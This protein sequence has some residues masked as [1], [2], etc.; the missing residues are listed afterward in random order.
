MRQS[1]A[2]YDKAYCIRSWGGSSYRGTANLSVRDVLRQA[3]DCNPVRLAA[4]MSKYR[5]LNVAEACGCLGFPLNYCV[6]S[7]ASTSHMHTMLGSSFS[8]HVIVHLLRPLRESGLFFTRAYDAEY[9]AF[10]DE[11]QREDD[12]SQAQGAEPGVGHGPDRT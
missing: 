11:Q 1:E 6:Q 10:E 4:G 2:L 5:K 12:A 8:V 3:H 7:N 9:A